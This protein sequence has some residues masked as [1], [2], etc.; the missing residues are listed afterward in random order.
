MA[1]SG[2]SLQIK[3]DKMPRGHSEAAIGTHPLYLVALQLKDKA[4][5][6]TRTVGDL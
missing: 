4:L 5:F 3:S 2:G 1:P 6:Q